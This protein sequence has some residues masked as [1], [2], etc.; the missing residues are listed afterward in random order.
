MISQNTQ[1]YLNTNKPYR[2]E[3]G[4]CITRI[5]KKSDFPSLLENRNHAEVYLT[6]N[7]M[8]GQYVRE[9]CRL[10]F[11][12]KSIEKYDMFTYKIVFDKI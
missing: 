12:K 6:D 10:G 5:S 3:Y 1:I 7:R 4:N 8:I 11:T 2:R 9:I